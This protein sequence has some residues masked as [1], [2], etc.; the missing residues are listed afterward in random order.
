[1]EEET[2]EQNGKNNTRASKKKKKKKQEARE[3]KKQTKEETY[4]RIE[5]RA[6]AT[7]PVSLP[8]AFGW[9]PKVIGAAPPAADPPPNHPRPTPCQLKHLQFTVYFACDVQKHRFFN[10]VSGPSAASDFI[11]AMLQNLGFLRGSGLQEGARGGKNWHLKIV[12]T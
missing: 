6:P 9:Q 8:E 12:S 10:G 5:I 2:Q 11:L 7:E 3:I 1:M 4:Y